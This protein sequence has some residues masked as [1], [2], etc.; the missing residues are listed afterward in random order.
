MSQ[1]IAAGK[2]LCLPFPLMPAFDVQIVVPRDMTRGEAEGLCA[3][4]MSL[5]A[6]EAAAIKHAE[7]DSEKEAR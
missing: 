5:A 3:F 2:S 4:V 1:G 6:P 7:A